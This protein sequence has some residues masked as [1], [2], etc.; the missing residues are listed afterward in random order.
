MLES[1]DLIQST[2]KVCRLDENKLIFKL[3]IK[4]FSGQIDEYKD[5]L[6]KV[7]YR[8]GGNSVLGQIFEVL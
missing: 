6:G 1:S 4:F 3:W 5:N 2:I 8:Y 7:F